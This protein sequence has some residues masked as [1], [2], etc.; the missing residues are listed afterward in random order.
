MAEFSRKSRAKSILENINTAQASKKQVYDFYQRWRKQYGVKGKGLDFAKSKKTDIVRELYELEARQSAEIKQAPITRFERKYE[1]I[2][3]QIKSPSKEAAEALKKL[4][5]EA[6]K[7]EAAGKISKQK[8][9]LFRVATEQPKARYKGGSQSRS[10]Q[11]SNQYYKGRFAHDYIKKMCEDGLLDTDDFE[12]SKEIWY[13]IDL[14]TNNSDD[15]DFFAAHY[16]GQ[17]KKGSRDYYLGTGGFD[18]F[19]T[20]CH[21]FERELQAKGKQIPE[22]Y[23]EEYW[24]ALKAWLNDKGGVTQL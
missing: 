24:E 3:E 5:K 22:K 1:K 19:L 12:D 11:R 15:F 9:D 14:V 17:Y 13:A 16:A 8:A 18:D 10:K 4:Q 6:A 2:K 21:D 20:A 7:L 23:T